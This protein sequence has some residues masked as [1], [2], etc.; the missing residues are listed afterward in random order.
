MTVKWAT[1]LYNAILLPSFYTHHLWWQRKVA[2]DRV[3][4]KR[5]GWANMLTGVCIG[6]VVYLATF[7]FRSYPVAKATYELNEDAAATLAIAG[8]DPRLELATVAMTELKYKVASKIYVA[9]DKADIRRATIQLQALKDAQLAERRREAE[10]AE[11]L[12]T[13]QA[14]A[15]AE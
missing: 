13:N 8:V 10:E 3:L 15:A 1:A 9:N 2:L 5:T 11:R 12:G 6:S 14:T 7:P 4:E